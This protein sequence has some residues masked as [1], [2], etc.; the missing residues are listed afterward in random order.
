MSRI[1]G[2]A[3][4]NVA[5]LQV[6]NPNA[7]TGKV[8]GRGAVADPVR[9][10]T[11]DAASLSTAGAVVAQATAGSD[12]RTDKVAALQAAIARGDYHVP[13]GD[14]ADKLIGSLLG[15]P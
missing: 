10:G 12:V 15:E 8:N 5:T 2:Y 11:G 6:T 1:N 9:A 3:A 14:V 13:A 7:E 4:P